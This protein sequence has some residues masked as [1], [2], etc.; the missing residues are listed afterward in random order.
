[1]CTNDLGTF[2][3]RSCGIGWPQ[4]KGGWNSPKGGGTCPC[5][6]GKSRCCSTWGLVSLLHSWISLLRSD[7]SG[8]ATSSG[9]PVETVL[10]CVEWQSCQ[11][12]YRLCCIQW[13]YRGCAACPEP[14]SEQS[15]GWCEHTFSVK[16][17]GLA[18]QLLHCSELC[19][20]PSAFVCH[21]T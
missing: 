7:M 11:G 3:F 16:A 4:P 10:G 15:T 9:A 20:L 1:M 17:G 5:W 2:V 14:A 21:D 12:W 18:A 19:A 8:H 13:D 6:W